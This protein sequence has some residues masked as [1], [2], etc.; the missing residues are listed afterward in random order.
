MQLWRIANIGPD[1]YYNLTLGGLTF[2]QVAQDGRL[3]NQL[4]PLTYIF[5][6]P[7]AR[8]EVFVVGPASGQYS[9]VT[10][11]IDTGPAGDQYPEVQLAT[12]ISSGI[13]C[14]AI[15]LPSNFPPV[16]DL[17]GAT[18]TKYRTFIFSE[19]VAD[20]TFFI[21][22]KF[23]TLTG[24]DTFVTQGDIEE[25]TIIN[26]ASEFH[27]FHIH[28]LGFQVIEQNGVEVPFYGMQET[29]NLPHLNENT[30]SSGSIK[31]ILAF[32]GDE[33]VGK[34]VYHCHI[35]NHEDNGMIAVIKVSPRPHQGEP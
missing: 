15:A 22:G 8:V 30:D 18:I 25:W 10:H 1:I 16:R 35:M 4:V 5:L 21:N 29:V 2:Y 12:L 23:G 33:V 9:L 11:Y 20:G 6:T 17:R 24:I 28:Q 14:D 7:A 13:G 26:N 19:S 31:I 32:D 27:V 3:R 34:F